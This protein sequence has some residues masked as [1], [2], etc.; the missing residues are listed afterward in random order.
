MT[1]A[2]IPIGR[3][4]VWAWRLVMAHSERRERRR[5]NAKPLMSVDYTLDLDYAGEGHRLQRLDVIAPRNRR[6]PLPVYVYFHGGGW[7]SG[8]KAAL[9]RYCAVQA[10]QGMVVVNVNYRTAPR[11]H[12]RHMLHDAAAALEWVTSTIAEYGGDPRRIIVGGDSAGGHIAA[13]V[14]A[15]PTNPELAEHYGLDGHAPFGIVGTV[16]H[17]SA[18]DF[19]VV[20]ERG[21][22][23]GLGFVRMLLPGRVPRSELRAASRLMSPIEWVGPDYP[24]TLVTTSRRDFFYGATMNFADALRA[25]GVRVESW[26]SERALHTWQQNSFHPDSREVYSRLHAFVGVVAGAAAVA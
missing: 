7:T 3:M 11:H 2:S 24:P 25:N 15:V 6:E 19:S 4:P 20:F 18:L 13:L 14:A 12:L 10:E 1:Q 17:C 9:T 8:D 23:M 5:F 21:F 16:Q 22:V 26:V